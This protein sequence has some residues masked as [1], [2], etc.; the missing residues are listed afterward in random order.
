VTPAVAQEAPE[1]PVLPVGSAVVPSAS[2]FADGGAPSGYERASVWDVVQAGDG[3]AVLLIDSKRVTVLPIFVGGT[4]AMTIRLRADGARYERPLTHD[5]L[6]SLVHELG[7]APVKSQIDDLRDDTYFG[8]VFVRQG[9]RVLQLDARPSDA[10]AIALGSG[11][12][13]YVSRSVM[14][15]SGVPRE[16]IE[17]AEKDQAL[18]K[19]RK[20]SRISL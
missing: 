12:P 3:A 2:T 13:L 4:E 7:G 18:D 5:L 14:L 17:K 1:A 11:A 16:E 6:S 15:A 8:S 20:G 10:I 19:R 9:D